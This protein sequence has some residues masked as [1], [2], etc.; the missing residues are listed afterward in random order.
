MKKANFFKT[1]AS[2]AAL[3]LAGCTS[4]GNHQ[5]NVPKSNLAECYSNLEKCARPG[6]DN[7]AA[8]GESYSG[9]NA[10]NMAKLDVKTQIARYLFG[11]HIV[12]STTSVKTLNGKSSGLPE[13]KGYTINTRQIRV[14][15]GTLP[16]IIWESE[17]VT[18]VNG[19]KCYVVGYIP[20]K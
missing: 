12:S 13:E 15:K 10:V 19:N 3:A 9:E 6:F 20:N 2:L 8:I 18:D 17:C 14:I 11:S 7:F 5:I 16:R 1:G 4:N